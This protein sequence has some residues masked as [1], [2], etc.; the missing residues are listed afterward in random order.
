LLD[1][2][3]QLRQM[4]NFCAAHPTK[5]PFQKTVESPKK[6]GPR[7]F[8]CD[9]LSC[10]LSRG[11]YLF[12][13]LEYFVDASVSESSE[14]SWRWPCRMACYAFPSQ[15]FWPESIS[16]CSPCRTDLAEL[17]VDVEKPETEH[18]A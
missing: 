7:R 15:V 1:E 5:G 14:S 8:G 16:D 12:D 2:R 4:N 17:G 11:N 18:S 10:E 3:A 6:Q 13:L 9:G